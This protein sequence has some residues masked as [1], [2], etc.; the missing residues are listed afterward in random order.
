MEM[1]LVEGQFPPRIAPWAIDGWRYPAFQFYSPL[2]YTLFGIAARTIPGHNPWVAIQLV[3]FLALMAGGIA[4]F[5][6]TRDISGS[7]AAATIASCAYITAP[8]LLVNMHGRAA[9][10]EAF[11]Q[12]VLPLVALTLWRT[13]KSPSLPRIAGASVGVAIIFFSHLIT[14]IYFL[15]AFTLVG[16]LESLLARTTWKRLL[17]IPAAAIGAGLLGAYYFLPMLHTKELLLASTLGNPVGWAWITPLFRLFSPIS[18]APLIDGG[19]GTPRVNPA[20]GV[21]IVACLVL[22]LIG[23]IQNPKEESH[24]IRP[25]GIALLSVIAL[26]LLFTWSPLDVWKAVPSVLYVVQFPYRLLAQIQWMGVLCVAL[27]LAPSLRTIRPANQLPVIVGAVFCILTSS[28]YLDVGTRKVNVAEIVREPD[29]GYGGDMYVRK[30]NAPGVTLPTDGSKPVLGTFQSCR[31]GGNAVSCDL[32]M[33]GG[34]VAQI[35]VLYY[36]QFL[37]VHVNGVEHA[38]GRQPARDHKGVER[39]L[40]ALELGPGRSVIRVEFVGSKLGNWISLITLCSL[41]TGFV[42]LQIVKRRHMDPA[43]EVSSIASSDDS[44]TPPP[45]KTI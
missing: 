16:I 38:F 22:L 8:Y 30:G 43:A 27:A 17:V 32:D 33:G 31:A 2:P 19:G 20:I 11:A 13:V 37:D 21:P 6:L 36:P 41:I 45:R 28:T 44:K 39:D 10:A 29:I 25:L 26:F 35:P 15:I 42:V 3:L 24:G 4:M 9:M 14:G 34:G 1:A 7:S 18:M 12:A 5:L 40:M 23:L